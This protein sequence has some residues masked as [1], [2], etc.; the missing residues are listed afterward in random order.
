MPSIMSGLVKR[1]VRTHINLNIA[2]QLV[3]YPGPTRLIRRTMD[4]MITTRYRVLLTL[5]NTMFRGCV[6]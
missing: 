6:L 2:E 1:A 3:K 5:G 4:E